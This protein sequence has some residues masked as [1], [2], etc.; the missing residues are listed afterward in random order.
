MFN[1]HA[2]T[3]P[4]NFLSTILRQGNSMM[5]SHAIFFNWRTPNS[6]KHLYFFNWQILGKSTFSALQPFSFWIPSPDLT[7]WS[8]QSI[9]HCSSLQV[10]TSISVGHALVVE[11]F[12]TFELVFTVFATCDPRRNDLKGSSALA[13]GLSVCIGHLFAVSTN[14][15]IENHLWFDSFRGCMMIKPLFQLY[16]FKTLAAGLV[17]LSTPAL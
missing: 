13:I 7:L 15:R 17:Y 16:C 14:S 6:L 4:Y 9:N 10:N 1:M 5:S 2:E 12:I 8:N 11:L 3:C